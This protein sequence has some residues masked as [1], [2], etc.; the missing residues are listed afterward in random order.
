MAPDSHRGFF[1]PI[2]ERN[3]L[4]ELLRFSGKPADKFF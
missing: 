1:V 4:T 2:G 3:A